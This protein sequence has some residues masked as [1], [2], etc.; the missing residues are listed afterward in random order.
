MYA[1]SEQQYT[2]AGKEI[3]VPKGGIYVTSDGRWSEEVDTRIGKANAVLRELY[4][5]VVTKRELSNTAELSVF[6]SVYVPILT[7]GHESWLL[8]DKILTEVQAATWA[9]CEECEAT[10]GRTE[11]RRRQ[12]A[13]KESGAPMFEPKIFWE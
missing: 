13:Q 2:A 1:A 10:Q 9:F 5:S 7:Y 4:R 11:V 8:T 3:Q 6:K 12:G